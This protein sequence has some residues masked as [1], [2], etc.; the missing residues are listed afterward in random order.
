[1]GLFKS[2]FAAIKR[3]L[4][5][6][7]EVLGRGLRNLL[8]GRQLSEELIDEIERRLIAADVGV[9]ATR[10]II[11][12]LR[13]DYRAGTIQKGDEALEFLK[14]QLKARWSEEDRRLANAATKPTVILVVGVNGAGK[15]TSVAKIAKSLRDEGRTV[16]LAAAD[17]F[18]AGAVAQL[19]I[20]AE[21]LGV[22]LVKGAQNA[23]P[24]AVAFDACDAAIARK[25]DVLL[26]D[27]A[28]RLHTQD[29]LMRQLTKIRSV[30]QKKI[31]TAPHETL[32]VLDAT[33]GQNAIEQA[34][35]FKEAAVVTGIFL[36]KLDGTAKGGIV[37]AIRDTLDV[38]V[39][40][41]GV[42]ERPE[43]VEPF[44]PDRFVEAMFEE[45]DV[46]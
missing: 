21:R 41:V 46:G 22:D 10:E 45:E 44:D 7:A 34:R 4:Q 39:K 35:I 31:P 37:V 5:K 38:P 1:M 28:G 19:T 9:K 42:G 36:A 16:L 33:S 15:T 40:L 17:T 13:A 25:V 24:A 11:A 6:T 18:R 29:H 43:D 20:W 3:G 23:D 32:L 30:V 2:A 14:R 12:A 27:T 26:I 8:R